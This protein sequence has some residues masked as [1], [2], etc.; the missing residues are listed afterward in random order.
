MS[1]GE[2]RRILAAAEYIA[3]VGLSERPERASHGIA[4]YLLAAGYTVY[5]VNPKLAGRT[6][7]GAEVYSSLAD[8]PGRID[9]VNVFRRSDAIPGITGET[10][11]LEPEKKIRCLWLQLGLYDKSSARRARQAGLTVVMDRCIKIEHAHLAR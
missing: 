6:I 2:L 10:L 9:I 7:A 11:E 8:V 4:K 3:V 1:D 5:G